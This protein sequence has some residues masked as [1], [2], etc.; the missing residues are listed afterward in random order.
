MVPKIKPV[1]IFLF[2][3]LESEINE[4]F[5]RVGSRVVTVVVSG[6][7]GQEAEVKLTASSR[8]SGASAPVSPFSSS[9]LGYKLSRMF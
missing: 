3:E 4:E 8:S 7:S 5:D 2:Q 1:C 9:E 6:A